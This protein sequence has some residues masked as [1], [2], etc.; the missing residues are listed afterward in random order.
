VAF[1][2][3]AVCERHIS[4]VFQ[5]LAVVEHFVNR[6]FECLAML[7]FV[8]FSDAKRRDFRRA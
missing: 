7:F 8:P 6:A 3:L 1:Q 4:V 5:R 2:R